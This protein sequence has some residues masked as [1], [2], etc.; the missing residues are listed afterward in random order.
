MLRTRP[1]LVCSVTLGLLVAACG[2]GSDGDGSTDGGDPS[3]DGGGGT[4]SDGGGGGIDAGK[5]KGDGGATDAGGATDGSVGNNDSGTTKDA[6]PTGC[7]P[8]CAIGQPCNAGTDCLSTICSVANICATGATDGRQD[9]GESDVDCGG[10]TTDNASTCATGKKCALDNDCASTACSVGLTCVTSG[11]T[12]GKQDDGESDIDCGGNTTDG[13]SA[14]A[15]GKMCVLNDDCTSNVCSAGLLCVPTAATDG[16]QDDGESDI[17]CGGNTTDNAPKCADGKMCVNTTDCGG[18]GS[19]CNLS[20]VCAQPT[21]SDGI[22]DGTETD[23]DCGGGAPTNAPA[24][25]TGKSCKVGADCASDGCS[26]L[27]K[28]A[29]AISCTGQHGGDTCGSTGTDTCCNTLPAAGLPQGK[30]N[31]VS[32]TTTTIDKY[33]ITAGRMRAFVTATNGDMR[34]WISNHTPAWWNATWTANL[35][36]TLN[37]KNYGNLNVGD[38]VYQEFGPNV[39]GTSGPANEGCYIKGNGARSYR[40]PDAVNA[41]FGD[42]QSWTQDFDD[43]RSMNCVDPYILAAFCAWDGGH[44]PTLT[45]IDYLWTGKLPWGSP[46]AAPAAGNPLGYEY[47]YDSDPMGGSGYN[48]AYGAYQAGPIVVGPLGATDLE[49][50]TYA[51]YNYNWWDGSTRNDTV[52][53]D[54]TIYI[55]QPGRFPNGDGKYGHSDLGGNVFNALDFSGTN[56]CW[57]RSGSWQG[58]PIPFAS[59]G[60]CGVNV[61]ATNK[62]WAMGG[63]CAR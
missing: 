58:H 5:T 8:T 3:V 60:N 25:A 45:Q 63:R 16:K 33:N 10:N 12:D 4:G 24:C 32:V 38:G 39:H 52:N 7:S 23:V 2:G 41:D 22:Q 47:A 53:H 62:Y 27:D 55:A 14:C 56:N 51:N 42:P 34:T 37:S 36:N 18:A 50:L 15:T 30:I 59:A 13:A 61:P 6:G 48:G 57:S 19:L 11:A 31:G 21:S 17:D 49:N 20:S 44:L 54:Y 46:A 28:C 1:L 35:P 9:N 29:P 26:Y 43:E 40:L